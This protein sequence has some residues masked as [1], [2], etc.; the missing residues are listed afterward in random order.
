MF[1]EGVCWVKWKKETS[2]EGVYEGW[3]RAVAEAGTVSEATALHIGFC[4]TELYPSGGAGLSRGLWRKAEGGCGIRARSEFMTV[5]QTQERSPGVQGLCLWIRRGQGHP[6]KKRRSE[7]S[8]K[9]KHIK[10]RLGSLAG[11]YQMIVRNFLGSVL[12]FQLHLLDW[13]SPGQAS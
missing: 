12:W 11:A 6:K 3:Q 13:S 9:Q 4:G 1:I 7:I 5:W 2:A 10:Q 8:E